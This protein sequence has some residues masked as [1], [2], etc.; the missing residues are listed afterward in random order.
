M[1][2]LV[3]NPEHRFPHD[4]AHMVLT[5]PM[6]FMETVLVTVDSFRSKLPGNQSQDTMCRRTAKVG[7]R[8]RNKVRMK[9]DDN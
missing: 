1:S 9:F 4:A 2:N 6:F 8:R 3:G 5:F 7:I